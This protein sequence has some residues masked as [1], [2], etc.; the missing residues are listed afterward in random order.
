[1][2]QYN[3][4]DVYDMILADVTEMD[5]AKEIGIHLNKIKEERIHIFSFTAK[6]YCTKYSYVSKTAGNAFCYAYVENHGPDG[7]GVYM[8][9]S[10]GDFDDLN[11]LFFSYLDYY[12]PKRG[13]KNDN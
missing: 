6:V 2:F 11:D 10:K 12:D 7:F 8:L 13:W 1:M 9:T 4:Y 3:G 5:K